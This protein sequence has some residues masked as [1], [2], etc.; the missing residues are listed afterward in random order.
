MVDEGISAGTTDALPS[1]LGSAATVSLI[2]LAHG[3]KKGATGSPSRVWCCEGSAH[4]LFDLGAFALWFVPGVVVA[5]VDALLT[6]SGALPDQVV[7]GALQFLDA[8]GQV[9]G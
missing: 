4:Q 5:A 8:V 2:T 1:S 3:Q 6:E 9:G 7:H